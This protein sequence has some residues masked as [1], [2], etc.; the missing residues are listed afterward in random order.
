MKKHILFQLAVLMLVLSQ[1]EAVGSD[2]SNKGEVRGLPNVSTQTPGNW[3]IFADALVWYA[4]EQASSVWADIIEIGDNTSS[5]AAQN[6]S[7]GWDAGFRLGVGY[8][9]H[10]DQWDTQLYWTWF[11]TKAHQNQ[12]VSPEFI[13]IS[14]GVLVTEEIHPEFF[15]ADLSKAFSEKASI[16]WSLLFNMI[17]WE[18]GRNYWVSKGLSLRP[19]IGIKGGW[20]DQSIRVEY[21]DLIINSAPTELSAKENVKNNF[22]GIGPVGGV[23]TQWK[24]RQFKSHFPSL[25]GNFSI[26]TLWGT[27]ICSDVYKDTTGK[28]ITVNTR[29]STL[30]ALMMRGIVGVGWDVEFNKGKSRFA[31]QLGY[32]M[33]LWVN[34]L[35]VATSQLVRLHGDLT[36]QGVT[37]NCRFDF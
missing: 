37:F 31:T 11:R 3:D 19:F 10:R 5:F 16:K 15:A 9:L 20:I 14:G 35:R 29:N 24:L 2:Q 23:N 17:D 33:Q 36:L 8:N 18:L 6:L 26:A 13:P 4:S 32:E 21:D 34:Q 7:F 25:F 28:K 12:D 22:W 1:A 27:W 30:G